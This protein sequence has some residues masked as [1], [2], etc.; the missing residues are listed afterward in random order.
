M[1]VLFADMSWPEAFYWSV[2]AICITVALIG[3][4]KRR[5]K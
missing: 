4:P 1:A 3:W 2:V 5:S